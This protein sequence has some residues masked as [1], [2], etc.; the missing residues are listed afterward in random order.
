MTSL[1]FSHVFGHLCLFSEFTLMSL[2]HLYLLGCLPIDPK[3]LQFAP[4]LSLGNIEAQLDHNSSFIGNG[5]C[6]KL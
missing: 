5:N 6:I 4:I 1:R 2:L 3:A